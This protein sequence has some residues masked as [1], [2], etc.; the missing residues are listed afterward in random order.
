MG[1][2]G[3][4]LSISSYQTVVTSVGISKKELVAVGYTENTPL[5]V[6]LS[7]YASLT[8][9]VELILQQGYSVV[10]GH[11]RVLRDKKGPSAIYSL[12]LRVTLRKPPGNYAGSKSGPITSTSSPAY[13][14]LLHGWNRD[15]MKG[16]WTWYHTT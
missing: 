13:Q 5:P 3:P 6:I 16:L 11:I 7:W 12:R 10:G 9:K 4:S 14:K 2:N 1:L 15:L 8:E